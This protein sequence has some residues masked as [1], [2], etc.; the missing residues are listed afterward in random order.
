MDK[1]KR[2][3]ADVR[4]PASR[5]A[6]AEARAA[7]EG[8]GLPLPC[9]RAARQV[10]LG[11]ATA[12]TRRRRSISTTISPCS[13]ATGFERGVHGADRPLR[14]R[15][16]LHRR[17]HQGASRTAAR[18]RADRRGH[19]RSRAARSRRRRRA[20]L[21]RQP[22]RQDRACRSTWRAG[23]PSASRTSAGTCSSC[24][25]SR[26]IPIST[27]MLG[28]FATEVVIDHMGRP[29]P[30]TGVE[31]TGLPGADPAA[32][33]GARLGQAVGALPHLAARAAL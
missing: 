6:Q 30:R 31:R 1:S 9:L 16:P 7:A 17:C 28:S 4:R 15:Q 8:R 3:P 24:S 29:D 18:H 12:S 21:P 11:R 19:H 14:Q 27:R 22:H 23:S 5:G 20:R 33:V 10:S 2:W 32:Q 25:T 26:I 13:R